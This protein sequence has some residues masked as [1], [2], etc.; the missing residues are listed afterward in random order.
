MSEGYIYAFES[1]MK[2]AIH[3]NQ[4]AKQYIK[5]L[6]DND[7]LYNLGISGN[8]IL[9]Y[10]AVGL[11]ENSEALGEIQTLFEKSQIVPSKDDK[12]P[13]STKGKSTILPPAQNWSFITDDL[14]R[15]IIARDYKELLRLLKISA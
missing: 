3:G 5:K 7:D 1:A 10:A 13:H 2:R 14:L 8:T 11:N 6:L 12:L 15:E 9:G 4:A